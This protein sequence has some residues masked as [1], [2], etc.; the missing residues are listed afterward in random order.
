M[1]IFNVSQQ[2]LLADQAWRAQGFWQRARGLLGQR[3]IS[4]QQALLLPHCQSIH[5][6][7][8]RFAIDVIFV[9]QQN[10]VVGLVSNIRPFRLSPF[11]LK[12]NYAIE[13]APG[14]ILLTKTS[15]GDRI[16]IE[17]DV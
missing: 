8:M 11:F 16:K 12:A 10:I 7:F 9:D 2:T 4:S 1:K 14:K 6:F 3:E 15:L 5:M 17:E 13:L